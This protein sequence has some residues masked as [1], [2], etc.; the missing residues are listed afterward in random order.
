MS[1]AVQFIRSG[2]GFAPELR[3]VMRNLKSE[4]VQVDEMWQFVYCK[5]KTVTP[6]IYRL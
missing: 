4:R 1:D 2:N 3:R 6:A 5:A